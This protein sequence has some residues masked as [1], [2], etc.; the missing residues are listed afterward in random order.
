MLEDS[1]HLP[2]YTIK[3]RSSFSHSSFTAGKQPT[4]VNGS[5]YR[6][7]NILDFTKNL[8]GL[9]FQVLWDKEIPVLGKMKVRLSYLQQ[10]QDL[11]L[12]A[13]SGKGS[14]QTQW[15]VTSWKR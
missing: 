5:R 3:V 6:S 4:I 11:W 10:S 14:N 1:E 8:P 12:E 9:Y 13:V 2:L 15:D 7:S